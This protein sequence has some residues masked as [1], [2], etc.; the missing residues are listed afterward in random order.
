MQV[1]VLCFFSHINGKFPQNLQHE[2]YINNN[3]TIKIKP[4]RNRRG[5][6][7]HIISSAVVIHVAIYWQ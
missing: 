1:A 3:T 7:F 4:R 5:L 6:V 2:R